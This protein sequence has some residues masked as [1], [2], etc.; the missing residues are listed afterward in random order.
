MT[1][2]LL[3]VPDAASVVRSRPLEYLPRCNREQPQAQGA[4]TIKL[5]PLV[6]PFM[7]PT[8]TCFSGVLN[9]KLR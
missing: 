1:S 4:K 6:K 2:L 8:E 9:K 7:L 3:L 5:K